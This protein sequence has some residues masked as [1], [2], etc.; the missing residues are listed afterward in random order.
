MLVE[1]NEVEV[2]AHALVLT[3]LTEGAITVVY[4]LRSHRSFLIL[5]SVVIANIISLPIGWYIFPAG[6]I[7]TNPVSL[8][9]LFELFAIVFEFGCI[10][11]VSRGALPLKQA[12]WLSI[13][14]NIISAIIGIFAVP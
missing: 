11:V 4:L 7:F 1:N 14:I 5:V 13:A 3:I 10:Y 12:F 8:N 6:G 9:G 2:L